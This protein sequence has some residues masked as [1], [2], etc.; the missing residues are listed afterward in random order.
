MLL[1]VVHE[2][3]R[4]VR[5]DEAMRPDLAVPGRRILGVD[6]R[7]VTTAARLR[8]RRIIKG[9]CPIS[10]GRRRLPVVVLVE[11]A[12]PAIVID[13]AIEVHFVA[14]RAEL[15]RLFG[16]ERLE[17]RIAVRRGRH[18]HQDIV[19]PLCPA[20]LAG[21]EVVQRRVFDR[22]I[23]LAHRAA[24]VHDRVAGRA[25]QTRLR[26]RRRDL[27]LDRP[28]EPPVE[29]HGVVVAAG[30]PFRRSCADG[31]LHVLDRLAVPLV[32]ERGEVVGRRVPL[33]VD[34]L[35]T[36]AARGA[37]HEEVRRNDAADVRLRRGRKERALRSPALR[38]HGRGRHRRILDTMP[39]LPAPF[40]GRPGRRS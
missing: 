3:Q 32:V 28:I 36:A 24:D 11:S 14:R 33:V 29:E 37:R 31:V 35:V 5:A 15:G 6:E 16:V 17:E 23:A 22:E 20:I 30:A 1:V 13:G 38:V 2:R 39:R 34:V 8:F 18:V 7:H 21:G 26:L 25:R 40:D 10:R 12:E 27:L 19:R 4:G 9:A